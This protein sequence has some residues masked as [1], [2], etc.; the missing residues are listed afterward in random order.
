MITTANYDDIETEVC[1]E[2]D[3]LMDE[4]G[5]GFR[6]AWRAAT[7]KVAG[8]LGLDGEVFRRQFKAVDKQIKWEAITNEGNQKSLAR[9]QKWHTQPSRFEA[10]LKVLFEHDPLG[11]CSHDHG[12][13]EYDVEVDTI[14]PR[15]TNTL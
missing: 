11:I 6:P 15:L 5:L 13:T 2:R 1:D 3:R 14:L 10:V 7:D 8:R 12:A 9:R 4:V